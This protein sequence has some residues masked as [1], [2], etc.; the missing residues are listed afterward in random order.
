M[1]RFLLV[2]HGETRY[3]LAEQ[4]GLIGAAREM[5]PL[6]ERGIR[7]IERRAERLRGTGLEMLVSSPLTRAL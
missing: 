4:R 3:D 6:T 5:V 7:Q 2:R 1:S